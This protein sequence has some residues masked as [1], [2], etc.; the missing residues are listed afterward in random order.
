MFSTYLGD[1]NVLLAD[2]ELPC[3]ASYNAQTRE[4]VLML[5]NVSSQTQRIQLQFDDGWRINSK[6]VQEIILTGENLSDA[7]S[8]G[9]ELVKPVYR[10]VSLSEIYEIPPFTFSVLRITATN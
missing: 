7:N 5:A 9:K 6:T 4:L 2:T 1:Y 3:Q 10:Q 8:M